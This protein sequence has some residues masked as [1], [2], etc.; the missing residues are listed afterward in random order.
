MFFF[1]LFFACL[2]PSPVKSQ[3]ALPQKI[4]VIILAGESNMAGPG[5]VFN[6]TA[7]NNLTWDS[8]VPEHASQIPLSSG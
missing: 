5:A 2:A 3:N 7:T 4:N 6:D 8:V 1:I